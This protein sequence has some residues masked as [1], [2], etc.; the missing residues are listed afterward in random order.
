MGYITYTISGSNNGGSPAKGIT[1]TLD[2]ATATGILV[3]DV[4][5]SGLIVQQ[6]PTGSAGAGTV[7]FVYSTD[8]TTWSTLTSSNLPLTGNGTVAIGMFIKGSGDFFPVGAQYTFTFQAQVPANAPAGAAYAN[9]ATVRYNNGQN[10]QTLT[11]NSTTNTVA[12]SYSVAVGPYGYPEG[13]ATG[14]YQAGQYTVTRSGDSQ[15]ISSAYDGT[16]VIF[17]HTLKNTGNTSDSFSL[18]LSGTPTGWTCSFLAEDLATP[19]SGPVGPVAAGGTYNFALRCSIPAGSTGGPFNLTVTATSQSDPTKSD[20]TSDSV[21]TLADGFRLDLFGGPQGGPDTQS[22]TTDGTNYTSDDSGPRPNL[23]LNPNTSLFPYANPGAQVVYRLRVQNLNPNGLADNYNLYAN[24]T[25]VTQFNNRVASVIFYPDANNDGNPDGPAI[26]NTGLV[27]A[28]Q[29]FYYL[30]VVTLKPDAPPGGAPFKFEARS[31]TNNE[32]DSADTEVW[33]NTVARVLLDPDRSGTVTSPGTIQ[34]THTLTNLSNAGATCNISGNG[35]SY[36]WTYQYSRDGTNWDSALSNV[37]V[38]A[39]GGSLTIYVRVIVPAGQPIG[40]TDVNTVTASCTVGA[41]T[42]TDTA[43]ETTTVVGGELR[44]QKSAKTYKGSG[45]D[46]R[47]LD[48]STAYPGDDIEYTVV[49]ENIGTGN[50]TQAIVTDPLP[51]YTTFVS[52]SAS[53]SGF[54]GTI[55]YSTDGSSWNTMAPSLSPGQS[56]YVAVDTNGDN[57]ITNA[58]VMPPGAKITITLRVRVQ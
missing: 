47:S 2:N 9:S 8:G 38:A 5:P 17:R 48:G 55:L 27:N 50:L 24:P 3:S 1:I 16:Q 52:V 41:A 37:F 25:D 18:S 40:R 10:D 49:A 39:N 12:A 15:S 53:I 20:T 44:L 26:T 21:N 35:G 33:V 13:G 23:Y 29:T 28:N 31:F 36:G 6:M 32:V 11:S 22:K 57:T 42:A 30:A 19:I 51:A 43:T 54:T 45:P 58:D 4:I 46:V 34:Y 7:T 14:S 56:V